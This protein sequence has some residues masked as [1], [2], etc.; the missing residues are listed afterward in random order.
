MRVPSIEGLV[1]E[2]M[3]LVRTIRRIWQHMEAL[4][5]Y[6]SRREGVLST[7]RESYRLLH[8]EHNTQLFLGTRHPSGPKLI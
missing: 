4:Y 8:I 6:H 1:G 7:F 2:H 5:E 3:A